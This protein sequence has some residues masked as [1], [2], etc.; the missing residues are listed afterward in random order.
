MKITMKHDQYSNQQ[1]IQ[2]I[3]NLFEVDV[4]KT[5][6]FDIHIVILASGTKL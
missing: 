2:C 6:N 5:Y 1:F 4:P 3:L